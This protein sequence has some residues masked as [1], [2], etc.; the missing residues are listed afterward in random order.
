MKS[1]LSEIEQRDVNDILIEMANIY[2]R[3][4]NQYKF[5]YQ[6]V[7]SAV[8]DKQDEDGLELDKIEMFISL[9]INQNL[10]RADINEINI[11]S[12]LKTQ[13]ENQEMKESGWRFNKINS[14]TIFFYKTTEL[15]GSCYVKV[16][17]RCSTILNSQNDDKYCF[18]WSIL[19]HLHPVDSHS[20]RILNYKEYFNDLK[21]DGF[22]F[23][24]GFKS[25][26]V[27]KF[28]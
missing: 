28:A 25:S 21:I 17:I 24:N 6:T 11:E 22:D 10:T 7:F 3:L 9:K 16:P 26:D 15:N 8:F 18:I 4:I 14:M 5:K 20:T 2:A 1:Y 19:A 23:S 13:I 12:Q 27:H